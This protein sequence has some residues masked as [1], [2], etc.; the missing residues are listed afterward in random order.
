MGTFNMMEAFIL[1]LTTVPWLGHWKENSE[2][3]TVINLKQ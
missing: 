1:P 2:F 3:P